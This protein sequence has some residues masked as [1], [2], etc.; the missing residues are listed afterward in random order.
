MILHLL[1]SRMEAA[2][3]HAYTHEMDEALSFDTVDAPQPTHPTH[4]VVRVAGAGWCQTDNHIIEG[5]WDPYVDQPLP[6]TLGHENAGEVVATGEAVTTVTEGDQV[7]CHPQAT[8]GVCRPC[9]QGEDMYCEASFFPGIDTDGGFAE[10]LLTNERAVVPLPDGVDPVDI[11][12]HADA[13]ITAYHAAK[14]VARRVD[15]GD[16]VLVVGIGGLG[17]IGLQALAAMTATHITAIDV[18][19]EARALARELGA[20]ATVDPT[21]EDVVAAVDAIT[22][23]GAAQLVDFVGSD[24]TTG[25]ASDLLRAGGDHHVVGYGG[26]IHVPAQDLISNEVAYRGTLVGRYTELQELMALVAMDAVTLR[27]ERFG[28]EAIND[29]AA[30]LEAGQIEGRAVIPPP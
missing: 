3:L 5:M 24:V 20:D 2:R 14:K 30:R 11:A 26:H 8:C 27:S 10:Q 13:G 22:D 1:H 23:G 4:V 19:P 12:P 29:V 17:H 28:F 9:R 16:H 18:K 15:P 7:I 25:Y 21:G 6:M